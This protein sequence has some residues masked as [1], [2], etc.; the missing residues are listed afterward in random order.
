MPSIQSENDL[1]AAIL[2][3]EIQ[4]NEEGKVLKEQFYEAYESIKPLNLIKNT[5]KDLMGSP[6]L[7]DQL[8]FNSVGMAAGYLTRVIIVGKSDNPVR[9]LLG[10]ALMF[11][12]SDL[13]AKNPE[14]IK[15]AGAGIWNFIQNTLKPEDESPIVATIKE[16]AEPVT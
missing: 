13:A 9:R 6:E 14:A 10:M 3:L 4:Q 15:S 5:L 1:R 8:L 2:E 11:G 7:K 12:V 16:P